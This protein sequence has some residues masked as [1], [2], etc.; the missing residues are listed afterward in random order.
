MMVDNFSAN[1]MIYITKASFDGLMDEIS[2]DEPRPCVR[3]HTGVWARACKTL[4]NALFFSIIYVL[5]A[6]KTRVKMR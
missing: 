3:V 5:V 2:I 4:A 1:P 6:I